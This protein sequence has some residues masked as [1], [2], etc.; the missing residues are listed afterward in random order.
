[1]KTISTLMLLTVLGTGAWLHAQDQTPTNAPAP[2]AAPPAAPAAVAP[3]PAPAAA[4]A[5]ALAASATAN[6]TNALPGAELSPTATATATGETNATSMPPEVATTNAPSPTVILP[7]GEVGLRMNFRGVP[8][9][10]V[11]NYLSDAAGFIIVLDAQVRGKVDMWSNTPLTKDEA[12]NLLN[13]VLNKNGYAAIRN[14]RTLTVV[15]RDEAKTKGI[16]VRQGNNPE[17]I[18]SNDEIVTQ[19][20][21]VR[22]VEATALIKDLQPLV[23]T[24]TTI[25]A[26]E[27]GNSII[28][29]DTQSNIRRVAEIIKAVD[30]SADEETLVRVFHLKFA[31]PAETATLLSGIFPDETRS[32]NSQASSRFSGFRSMF[33][34]RGGGSPFGGGGDTGSSGGA[35]QRLKK[36]ARVIAVADPRT[37]SV[38]VTAGK[39]LMEQIAGMIE[40]LDSSPAKKQKVYVYSLDNA[41]ATEVEQVLSDMFERN[42]TSQNRSRSGTTQNNAL[43]NRST[44]NQQ[45]SRSGNNSAF[46]SSGGRSSG[47]GF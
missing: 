22:T 17:N 44:Q 27:A 14:G 25:T 38:I 1:M 45:N 24:T 10:M 7:N 26:N 6:A 29:T 2:G 4:P 37:S 31:D 43:Q 39:D 33:G 19:I 16:P 13:T 8:L 47:G 36:R 18:P 5:A 40:Q 11:L 42:T 21:P 28:I 46:G 34:G 3:T 20:I 32:N 30:I 12:V 35:N 41:D 23:S 9:E 15:N